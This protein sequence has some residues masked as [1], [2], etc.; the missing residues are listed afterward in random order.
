[1]RDR[2]IDRPDLAEAIQRSSR[3]R[4]RRGEAPRRFARSCDRAR[5]TE[6]RASA[7]AMD[8]QAIAE[9]G[10]IEDGSAGRNDMDLIARTSERTR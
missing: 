4:R 10:R 6:E 3:E 7:C 2:A 1:M 5:P 8:D 9:D